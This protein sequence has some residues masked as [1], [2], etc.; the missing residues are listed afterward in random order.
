MKKSEVSSNAVSRNATPAIIE[1]IRLMVEQDIQRAPMTRLD[2]ERVPNLCELLNVQP[3]E[4]QQI[5][6]ALRAI[7]RAIWISSVRARRKQVLRW[8]DGRGQEAGDLQ[9]TG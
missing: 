6:S 1:R 2:M 8:D 7:Y 5:E 4:D 3:D 9:P